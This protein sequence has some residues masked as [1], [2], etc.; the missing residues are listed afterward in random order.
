MI[1]FFE[2]PSQKKPEYKKKKTNRSFLIGIITLSIL[3]LGISAY[4][5]FDVSTHQVIDAF[6]NGEFTQAP[7]LMEKA[8]KKNAEFN[9]LREM[10]DH[11]L[12]LALKFEFRS[13]DD[14]SAP[15]LRQNFTET[16]NTILNHTHYYRL[17]IYASA[18]PMPLY[19]YFYQEDWRGKA[20]PL[21]PN[22][23]WNPGQ[24]NPVRLNFPIIF[25]LTPTDG[26]TWISCHPQPQ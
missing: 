14:P 7:R 3:F 11:H 1:L 15:I 4:L 23:D 21:F 18:A 26:F 12:N 22:P 10:L 2:N 17:L 25:R 5:Y 8:S 19:L 13:A 20:D 9:L 16:H 6:E 24:N